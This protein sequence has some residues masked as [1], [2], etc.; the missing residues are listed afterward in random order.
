[1]KWKPEVE[2]TEQ[3]GWQLC[4]AGV[5]IY[6][7]PDDVHIAKAMQQGICDI[8]QLKALI[9]KVDGVNE[10]DAALTLARFILHYSDFM[11]NDG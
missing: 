11:A 4:M 2:L 3:N 1:M 6:I 9:V 5:Q 7:E 8:E 10:A